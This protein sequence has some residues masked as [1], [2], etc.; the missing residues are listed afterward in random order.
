MNEKLDDQRAEKGS[1]VFGGL[2]DFE[3]PGLPRFMTERTARISDAALLATVEA[4]SLLYGAKEFILSALPFNTTGSGFRFI[5]SVGDLE[6]AIF[7]LLINIG[8]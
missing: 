6:R 7:S 4:M 1:L 8:G 2:T 5:N 3:E